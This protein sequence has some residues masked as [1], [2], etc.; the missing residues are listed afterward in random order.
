MELNQEYLKEIFKNF[1]TESE[2]IKADK[3]TVGHINKTYLVCTSRERYVLQ[4]INKAVFKNAKRLIL[5]KANISKHLVNKLSH[6]SEEER[7]KRVLRFVTTKDHL[8]YFKDSNSNFWNLTN[9]IEKSHTFLKVENKKMAFEGGRL[10][11]QFLNDISD[12]DIN[13]IEDVIPNFHNVKFRLIQFEESLSEASSERLSLAKNEIEFIGKV[14]NEMCIIQNLIEKGKIPIQI[15]HNDT[16]ISN[17]LFDDNCNGMCL[18]DTD[19]VMKGIVLFDLGD[20]IRTFCSSAQEDEVDLKKVLFNLSNFKALLKGFFSEQPKCIS[21]FEIKYI[22]LAAK[23]ITFVMGLRMLTDFL[24]N[25]IYFNIKYEHHNLIRARNQFKLVNEIERYFKE[26]KKITN[27]EYE[28][29][30][31]K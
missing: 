24:N 11:S 8:P 17:M 7:N 16:K 18:I 30:I 28:N 6:L 3:L 25:D 29:L 9:Y 21:K 14:K 19:T 26:L 15:T 1:N 23:T 12:Y 4:Q 5:N 22:P 20:A 2:F 27:S 13:E 31:E 10:I